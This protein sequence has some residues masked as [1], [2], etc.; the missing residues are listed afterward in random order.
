MSFEHTKVKYFSQSD[1]SANDQN[2][3]LSQKPIEI[4]YFINPLCQKSWSLEPYLKKLAIEYGRYFTLRPLITKD[5]FTANRADTS[6]I[7]ICPIKQIQFMTYQHIEHKKESLSPRIIALA[8]KAAELQGKSAG[9]KFLQKLQHALLLKDIRLYDKS[10]LYRCAKLTKLDIAEFKKDLF[11]KTARKALLC[12]LK[13]AHEM[14]VKHAPTIVFMNSLLDEQGI[15][16]PGLYS[17]DIYSHVFIKTLKDNPVREDAP[18]LYEY[19]AHQEMV[20]TEEISIVYDWSLKK[21]E[22]ELKKLALQQIVRMKKVD[23]TIL[24]TYT[25][26]KNN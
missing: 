9:R 2:T 18:L 14:D 11:S 7:N 8:I 10:L 25:T 4:Y 1:T 13:I 6:Y 24:W 21:A 26:A 22:N 12:D 19:I 5:F 20:T 16:V 23:S 17:Y 3:N 15:K